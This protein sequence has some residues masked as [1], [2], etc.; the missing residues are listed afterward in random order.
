MDIGS[1]RFA[2]F[3]DAFALQWDYSPGAAFYKAPSAYFFKRN[4]ITKVI[5]IANTTHTSSK[6]SILPLGARQQVLKYHLMKYH[7]AKYAAHKVKIE[8]MLG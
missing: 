7:P 5:A 6:S 2:N 8:G 3:N 4:A 1:P